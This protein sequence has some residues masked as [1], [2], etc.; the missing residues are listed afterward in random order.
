M[1]TMTLPTIAPSGAHGDDL[2]HVIGPGDAEAHGDG[3]VAGR[4]DGPLTTG[5]SPWDNAFRF[6]VTPMVDTR[7]TKPDASFSNFRILSGP[8]FGVTML[9]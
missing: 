7:Y 4:G 3:R 9:M 2:A 5:C 1:S 6:P 8:V